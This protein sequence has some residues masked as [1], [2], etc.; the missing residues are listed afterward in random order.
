MARIQKRRKK[1]GSFTYTVTIRKGKLKH[2]PEIRTFSKRNIA[3]SWARNI[4]TEIE[5]GT[6]TGS[7]SSRSYKVTDLITRY[8][9]EV[10]PHKSS[11]TQEISKIRFEKL[12]DDCQGYT[13]DRFDNEIM[14]GIFTSMLDRITKQTEHKPANLQKKWSRGYVV[15]FIQDMINV[16]RVA[17]SLWNV[18]LPYGNVAAN[19]RKLMKENYLLVGSDLHKDTRLVNDQ[20]TRLRNFK[21]NGTV[22]KHF[23]LFAIETGMRRSEIIG[24]KRSNIDWKQRIYTL[25]EHKSDAKRTRY[26]KGREVPLTYRAVALLRLVIWSQKNDQK[27]VWPWKGKHAG[28]TAYRGVKRIF[29]KLGMQQMTIHDLRHEFGSY[30][31]DRGVDMRLIG[32]AMGHQSLNSTKR[33]THPDA[34]KVVVLFD[35][36]RS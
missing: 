5:R 2:S 32:A 16:F 26:K 30:H 12:L 20:Y 7:R 29:K 3:E 24:M 33:Y 6:Y 4:E 25:E 13:L 22:F 18:P 14:Y 9:E 1:D 8:V 28:S 23:A 10:L 34:K 19:A 17:G 36:K 27:A 11:G 15:K 21:A 35:E 31:I